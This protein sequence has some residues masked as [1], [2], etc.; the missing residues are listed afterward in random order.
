MSVFPEKEMLPDDQDVFSCHP[1]YF[2][3]SEPAHLLKQHDNNTT[4]D[5]QILTQ[6]ARTI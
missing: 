5:E 3:I 6:C 2:C 4:S 1:V